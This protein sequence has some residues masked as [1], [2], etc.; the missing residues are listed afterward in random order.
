MPRTSVNIGE[1]DR[2]VRLP[3]QHAADRRGDIGGRQASRRDLVK[4]RLEQMVVMTI[5]HDHI[6]LRLRGREASKACA[7]Y[8]LARVIRNVG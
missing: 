5:D 6:H 4:Q 8:L 2:C 7:Y 1:N 3:A